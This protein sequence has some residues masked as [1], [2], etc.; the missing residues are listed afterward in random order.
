MTALPTDPATIAALAAA[1]YLLVAAGIG[2]RFLTFRLKVCPVCRH[3]R[4][5][6]TCRWR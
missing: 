5:Q 2:K 1:V 4:S 6:C 3:L